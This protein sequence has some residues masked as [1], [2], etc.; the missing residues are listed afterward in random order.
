MSPW[1]HRWQRRS[2]R[3]R[4]PRQPRKPW[5]RRLMP[6][7]R[8]MNGRSR[9]HFMDKR[10][11][12]SIVIRWKCNGN[13]LRGGGRDSRAGGLRSRGDGR[14]DALLAVE[15]VRIRSR[16]ECAF[17]AALT[18]MKR[19]RQPKRWQRTIRWPE[20]R[21]KKGQTTIGVNF[22]VNLRWHW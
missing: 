16:L 17:L 19:M 15:R 8:R 12:I 20:K 1:R 21:R 4:L 11:E 2:Q 14:G 10:F 3:R 7:R 6:E 18:P 13:Y 9:R 5:R 22:Q